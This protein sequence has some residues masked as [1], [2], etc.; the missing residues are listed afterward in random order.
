MVINER[1]I[2]VDTNVPITANKAVKPDADSDVPF[3]CIFECIKLIGHITQKGGLVID[4]CDEIFGEYRHKLSLKGQPGQG[5]VFMKW[6]HDNQWNIKKVG[7]I[8]I[9]KNG[10]TYD[11]F[12]KHDTLAG[13]DRSD[14]KFIAAANAHPDKPPVMQAAD[15]KWWGYNDALQQCGI[16]VHFLCPDYIEEKY[17]KKMAS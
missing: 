8:R 15:S 2:L 11:E 4:D 1:E 9:T 17:N 7:R 12:P 6:V 14:R 13:F 3:S 5:N 16:V 10:D